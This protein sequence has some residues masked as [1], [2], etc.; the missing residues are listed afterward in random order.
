MAENLS[1]ITERPAPEEWGEDE[2]LTLPEAAALLWPSGPLTTATLRTAARR[3]QLK[4]AV[5][6]GKHFTSRRALSELTKN[7]VVLAG[8]DQPAVPDKKDDAIA[9]L[10]E[11]VRRHKRR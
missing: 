1:R 6:A 3:G 5:I 8:A 11:L 7:M 10:D 9:R 4:I 2:L